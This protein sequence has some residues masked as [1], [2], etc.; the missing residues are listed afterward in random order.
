[1][2][3]TV[4]TVDR[5]AINS[6][7]VVVN[8]SSTIQQM[9]SELSSPIQDTGTQRIVI[10]FYDFIYNQLI[11]STCNPQVVKKLDIVDAWH[12]MCAAEHKNFPE[13]LRSLDNILSYFTC[14]CAVASLL[15]REASSLTIVP[16]MP[17][18]LL[19]IDKRTK[20]F[21][22]GD[23]QFILPVISKSN[24]V[25]RDI[26][27]HLLHDQAALTDLISVMGEAFP[28]AIYGYDIVTATTLAE[29]D[30]DYQRILAQ[31]YL[32]Y[33]EHINMFGEY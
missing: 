5:T 33:F 30:F 12:L 14:K 22:I 15:Y 11:Y 4:Y 19:Q 2:E 25:L 3:E 29:E 28:R 21:K 26:A 10:N 24:D 31:F 20:S 1:M 17:Q 6:L 18:V 32:A 13:N 8:D 23:S 9:A 7:L 16:W 27:K